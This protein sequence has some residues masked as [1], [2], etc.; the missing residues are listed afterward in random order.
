MYI[1]TQSHYM[2]NY[3]IFKTS[4]KKLFSIKKEDRILFYNDDEVLRVSQEHHYL[5]SK[6]TI[7]DIVMSLSCFALIVSV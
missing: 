3:Q 5:I 7:F 1:G 6:S 4:V 2:I